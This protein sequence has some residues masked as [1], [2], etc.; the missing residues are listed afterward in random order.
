MELSRE[1]IIDVLL[2]VAGYLTAGA[3]C[4]VLYS[5]V[6]GRNR[7][8]AQTAPAK[9]TQ[10]V[11]PELRNGRTTRKA[12]FVSFASTATVRD[13]DL[14]ERDRLR[15]EVTRYQRNR[16]EVI[17]IAREMLKSGTSQDNIRNLLPISEGELALLSNE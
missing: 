4:L 15:S 6:T 3:L 12:E 13:T 14:E 17:R 2:N 10:P 8:V 16:A 1:I 5:L 7:S 9:L 11:E